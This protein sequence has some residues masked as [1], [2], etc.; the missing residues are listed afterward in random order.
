MLFDYEK[1][2]S[3]RCLCS[4]K[5]SY[6]IDNLYFLSFYMCLGVTPSLNPPMLTV[7]TT[8]ATSISLS[9]TSASSEVYRYEVMWQ[10]NT[11]V[12][13][14]DVDEGNVTISGSST[15]YVI[16]RLK[17]YSSYLNR[18]TASNAAGSSEVSN[19]VTAMTEEA[20]RVYTYRYLY[21]PSL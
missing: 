13:C 8:T 20:G 2:E 18:V 21:L 6:F 4:I 14:P 17:E 10:R 16:K 3:E 19:T 11:S 12:G 1:K 15:H 5:H 7:I 9:W